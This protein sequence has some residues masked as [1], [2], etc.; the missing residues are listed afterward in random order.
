[1]EN[2]IEIDYAPYEETVS[3]AI[4]ENIRPILETWSIWEDIVDN[5]T[6]R[7]RQVQ[8]PF[9]IADNNFDLRE[10]NNDLEE[11]GVERTKVL[12]FTGGAVLIEFVKTKDI[13]F[14]LQGNGE[15]GYNIFVIND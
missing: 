2:T 8:S 13:A 12:T 3:D 9:T 7:V 11:I 1:M 5:Y 4:P 14:V 10:C 15:E 6:V